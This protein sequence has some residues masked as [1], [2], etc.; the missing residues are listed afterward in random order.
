MDALW[1]EPLP[2]ELRTSHLVLVHDVS[3]VRYAIYA[4]DGAPL[5]SI[6]LVLA[7]ERRAQ[8]AYTAM[9]HAAEAVAVVA[10]LA[11]RTSQLMWLELVCMDAAQADLARQL[12]FVRTHGAVW[13]ADC[14]DLIAWHHVRSIAVAASANVSVAGDT[15][16]ITVRAEDGVELELAIANASDEPYVTASTP[17]GS[18][19]FFSPD[20]S[21]AHASSL[22]VGA[23]AVRDEQLELRYGCSPT[24]FTA[25]CLALLLHEAARLRAMIPTPKIFIDAFACAL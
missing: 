12:G 20:D 5:G 14:D 10:E 21:L 1:N 23:L 3:A 18:T 11:A 13:S 17:I 15:G 8:I 9:A 7:G 16:A 4:Q 6:E 19:D 25:K 24:G 2:A 22:V